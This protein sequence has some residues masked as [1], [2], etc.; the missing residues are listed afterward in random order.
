MNCP[1]CDRNVKP[2]NL[3]VHR[4]RIH[5]D[6]SVPDA[7]KALEAIRVLE[8]AVQVV[9]DRMPE[10]TAAIREGTVP[11]GDAIADEWIGKLRHAIQA[12]DK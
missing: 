4:W 2:E 9:D 12:L 5:R 6:E 11:N 8:N 1:I 10:F 7:V 3:L